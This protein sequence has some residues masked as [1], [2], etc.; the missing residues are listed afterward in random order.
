VTEE[1]F[2][3]KQTLNSEDLPGQKR[4][5]QICFQHRHTGKLRKPSPY[6][7]N[8]GG[9]SCSRLEDGTQIGTLYSTAVRSSSSTICAKEK[10]KQHKLFAFSHTF[11]PD[12][13]EKDKLFLY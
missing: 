6:L 1:L 7:P 11:Q 5:V 3:V 12:L 9:K 10:P 13:G 2:Y 8:N 4:V